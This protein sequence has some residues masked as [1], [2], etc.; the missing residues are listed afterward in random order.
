M[1]DQL[2]AEGDDDPNDQARIDNDWAEQPVHFGPDAPG[3]GGGCA[4]VKQMAERIAAAKQEMD[5]QRG[6]EAGEGNG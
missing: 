3:T 2:L 6:R 5:Q 1:L 4:R